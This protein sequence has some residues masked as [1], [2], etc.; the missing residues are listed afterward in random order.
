MVYLSYLIFKKLSRKIAPEPLV[1]IVV[2]RTELQDQTIEDFFKKYDI[3]LSFPIEKVLSFNDLIVNILNKGEKISSGIYTVLIQKFRT[4]AESEN[5][6]LREL[7]NLPE[8]V[9]IEKIR[10]KKDIFIFI[11]E[12]HRSQYG[13]LN[14]ILVDLFNSAFYIAFTGTPKLDKDKNTFL[15]FGDPI[16]I[17]FIDDAERD[18]FILP[19]F[20][21]A[22]YD[23]SLIHISEPTR[24]Y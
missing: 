6:D 9:N 5:F 21:K 7:L 1:L 3:D 20:Y 14:R 12:A 15:K 16:D 18:G 4:R 23:L 11:D 24:P 19:V 8:D 17:Y 13:I 2:D 10:K 22:D